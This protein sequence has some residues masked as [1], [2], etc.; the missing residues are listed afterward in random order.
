MGSQ[1]NF[2][3][4]T[5]MQPLQ[6]PEDD[7][8]QLNT[9]MSGVVG[10]ILCFLKSPLEIMWNNIGFPGHC[11]AANELTAQISAETR[12][13]W[14][15]LPVT[16][17]CGGIQALNVNTVSKQSGAGSALVQAAL[18]GAASLALQLPQSARGG[19]PCGQALSGEKGYVFLPVLLYG[20]WFN[21]CQGDLGSPKSH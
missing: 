16:Q 6:L 1:N 8:L 17:L 21:W 3:S 4:V 20:W 15:S 10:G 18:L 2:F 12:S 19:I 13:G 11:D 7:S 5:W 9:K 14:W